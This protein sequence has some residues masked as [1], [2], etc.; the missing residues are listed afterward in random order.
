MS[1]EADIE[2]VAIAST[3]ST[4]INTLWRSY[5]EKQIV[6]NGNL[7]VLTVQIFP[8]NVSAFLFTSEVV[9]YLDLLLLPVKM[10]SSLLWGI[11]T[12]FC[13]IPLSLVS[14]NEQLLQRQSSGFRI[15]SREYGRRNPSRW[16]N[17]TLY[18]QEVGTN[19]ADKRRSHGRCSSLADSSYRFIFF[20][21]NEVS[22]GSSTRA[23][24]AV[25]ICRKTIISLK[26][27]QANIFIWKETNLNEEE[28]SL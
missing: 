19:L 2:V 26:I 5:D 18:P 21:L 1:S 24:A 3:R 13:I 9:T 11:I 22:D 10:C 4:A 25:N 20:H 14:T 8:W 6:M 17:G 16:P 12:Y 23:I 15:E 27:S 28:I 7:G